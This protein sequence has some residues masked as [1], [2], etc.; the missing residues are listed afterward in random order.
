M[1]VLIFGE[2]S[3]SEACYL[4]RANVSWLGESW[5]K[6]GDTAHPF[7]QEAAAGPIEPGEPA[8]RPA[9]I[10][11][12]YEVES[13]RMDRGDTAMTMQ[14]LGRAGGSRRTGLRR[15][16]LEPGRCSFPPHCHSSEE[17]LY[18][19]LEGAGEYLVQDQATP[20]EWHPVAHPVAAGDVVSA[21]AG[22]GLAHTFRA[23]PDGLVVLAYGHRHGYDVRWYPRSRKLSF[24]GLQLIGRFEPTSYWDGEEEV[25]S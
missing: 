1:T 5:V 22:N 11:N 15:L 16:S 25:S 9:S 14:D 3:D 13:I 6:A 19:V 7:A 24:A 20:G 4:P 18:V 17:E 10:V 21:P 8:A 12:L 23:G 2:R